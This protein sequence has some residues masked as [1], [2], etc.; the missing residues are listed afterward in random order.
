MLIF[1]KSVEGKAELDNLIGRLLPNRINN[2]DKKNCN[3]KTSVNYK[4]EKLGQC[5]YITLQTIIKIYG[6]HNCIR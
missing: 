2:Y 5:K 3:G 4:K 1:L 6:E